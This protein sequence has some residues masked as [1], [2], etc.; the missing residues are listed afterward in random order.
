MT[1]RNRFRIRMYLYQFVLYGTL[2]VTGIG[3]YYWL[4]PEQLDPQER[5]YWMGTNKGLTMLAVWLAA[6]IVYC[7]AIT[8]FRCPRCHTRLR[9]FTDLSGLAYW[10][11]GQDVKK[12]C[13]NCGLNFDEEWPPRTTVEEAVWRGD[14]CENKNPIK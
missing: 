9:I 6:L 1:P 11:W 14:E 10:S 5:E 7:V 13:P 8:R 2:L 4:N 12:P 3:G